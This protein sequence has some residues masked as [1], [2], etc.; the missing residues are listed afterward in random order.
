MTSVT[1]NVTLFH[2]VPHQQTLAIN[3][4]MFANIRKNSIYSRNLPLGHAAEQQFHS[5]FYQHKKRSMNNSM[6]IDAQERYS[7]MDIC[8]TSPSKWYTDIKFEV[9]FTL[10]R[11]LSPFLFSF[12]L[13]IYLI[14][15]SCAKPYL[16]ASPQ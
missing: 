8:S 10:I 9:E 1:Q 7:K 16:F 2:T 11:S 6:N 3:S 15:I 5:K 12:N 4:E 13:F 14:M